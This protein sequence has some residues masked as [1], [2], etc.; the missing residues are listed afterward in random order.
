[1]FIS[2]ILFLI[3]FVLA[4]VVFYTLRAKSA[5]ILV[6]AVV[7]LMITGYTGYRDLLGFSFPLEW[8]QGEFKIVAMMPT[9]GMT[10]LVIYEDWRSPK[11]PR[12]VHGKLSPQQQAEVARKLKS[13]GGVKGGVETDKT[14][15]KGQPTEGE[16]HLNLKD[17]REYEKD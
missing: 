12:W 4:S 8:V 9:H 17:I 6:P 16:L 5:Y 13:A 10:Y 15:K 11:T 7:A 3:L 1:M 2:V 14:G